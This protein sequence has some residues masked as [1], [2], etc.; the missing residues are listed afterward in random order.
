MVTFAS[1]FLPASIEPFTVMLSLAMM[2]SVV[3][4]TPV[5]AMR[6]SPASACDVHVQ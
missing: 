3:V 1:V 6:T 5:E 4:P 2:S